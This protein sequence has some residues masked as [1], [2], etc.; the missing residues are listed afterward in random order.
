MNLGDSLNT[1]GLLTWVSELQA[2]N[3][4]A[5]EPE[6][7]RILS[8]V[9]RM[10]RNAFKRYARVG[11]FVEPDDVVQNTVM[12]LLNAFRAVRPQSTRDFY[13]LVNE[14]IRREFLDLTRRYFGPNKQ[15]THLGDV[16]LGEGDGEYMPPGLAPDA[17][18]DQLAAFHE[19]VAKLPAKEQEV[20]GL[21]YYHGWKQ[22]EIAAL[23][24]VSTRTVQRWQDDA[25]ARIREA[26][27]L[28]GG[29]AG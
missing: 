7:R 12:R 27:A 20:I 19:V 16:Q 2:G 15:G 4:D 10:T 25:V 21:A 11:R 3:P 8:R 5:A 26:L 14:L 22:S 1:R 6:F 9:E 13:A 23:F 18:V 29:S 28:D 17:D 24:N